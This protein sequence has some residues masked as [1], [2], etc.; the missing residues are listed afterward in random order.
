MK[1]V[2]DMWFNE[3]RMEISNAIIRWLIKHTY[4]DVGVV[5][6]VLSQ[7]TQKEMMNYVNS[8][9]GEEEE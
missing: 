4:I 5:H 7:L 9:Y 8:H 2:N 6:A 1:E 3:K